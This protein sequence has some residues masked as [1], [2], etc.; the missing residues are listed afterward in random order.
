[1][2]KTKKNKRGQLKWICLKMTEILFSPFK[3]SKLPYI[4]FVTGLVFIIA[5]LLIIVFW[6]RG[7]VRFQPLPCPKFQIIYV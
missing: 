2:A 3:Y 4:L 1:M 6:Q 5:G 7:F